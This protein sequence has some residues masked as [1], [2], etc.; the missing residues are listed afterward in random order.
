[1]NVVKTNGIIL[2]RTNF[3]EADRILTVLTPDQGKL[4]LI[5]KGVRKERSKMAGGVEL[6]SVNELSFI[7]GRGEIGTLV[8]SRL[9]THFGTIVKDINRTMYGYEFLKLINKITEDNTEAEYFHLAEKVLSALDD[10]KL[11]LKL[12][13]LW[14]NMR[15]MNATGHATNLVTDTK[16]NSLVAS[17]NYEF[18]MGEMGFLLSQN[19]AY[20]SGHI[21]LLRLVAKADLNK[22]GLVSGVETYLDDCHHLAQTMLRSVLHV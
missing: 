1:M 8:S 19:G 9:V 11:D 18:D 21:K 5:A 2:A 6:F 12:V 14:A 13:M 17:K 7:R 22:I 3:Q 16:G 15:L 10:S 4:R 20:K